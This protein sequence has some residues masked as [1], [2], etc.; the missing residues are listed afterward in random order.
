M[1]FLKIEIIR[2]ISDWLKSG[3]HGGYDR[4]ARSSFGA[5]AQSRRAPHDWKITWPKR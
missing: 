2:I 4:V 5:L 1:L 3:K